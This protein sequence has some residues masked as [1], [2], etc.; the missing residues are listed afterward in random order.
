MTPAHTRRGPAATQN[1]QSQQQTSSSPPAR[2]LSPRAR[3]LVE[4]CTFHFCARHSPEAATPLRRCW[5]PPPLLR[6]VRVAAHE[7]TLSQRHA[8]TSSTSRRVESP[9][10]RSS[11]PLQATFSRASRS[12]LNLPQRAEGL[13]HQHTSPYF[14]SA[15]YST[16]TCVG[17]IPR[18]ARKDAA[19][20]LPTH[21]RYTRMPHLASAP[22]NGRRSAPPSLP[23][24]PSPLRKDAAHILPMHARAH[25]RAIANTVRT[26]EQK[27]VVLLPASLYHPRRRGTQ[28][29]TLHPAPIMEADVVRTSNRK[30][31]AFSRGAPHTAENGRRQS[32]R[33]PPCLQHNTRPGMKKAMDT[34]RVPVHP[35]RS[36]SPSHVLAQ[37][38]SSRFRRMTSTRAARASCARGYPSQPVVA[39]LHRRVRGWMRGPPSHGRQRGR[40]YDRSWREDGEVADALGGGVTDVTVTQCDAR[41]WR[42]PATAKEVIKEK[43]DESNGMKVEKDLGAVGKDEMGKGG[44]RE[45]ANSPSQIHSW[46]LAP[47]DGP[48]KDRFQGGSQTWGGK[49]RACENA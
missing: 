39:R 31:P 26:S 24:P 42:A 16:P 37:A 19:H 38:F 3:A 48:R 49:A 30:V 28:P 46:A 20:T 22:V 14:G 6:P 41:K 15:F 10:H 32:G 44:F 45:G 13:S 27:P 12:R 2:T 40:A 29:I 9:K 17:Y 33:A 23:L 1:W 47:G 21:A 35:S 36:H 11:S 4:Y 5:G 34:D 7:H 43:R 8:T 18:R 25:T